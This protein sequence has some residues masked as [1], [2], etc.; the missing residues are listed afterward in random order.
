MQIRL[1]VLGPRESAPTSGASSAHAAAPA[2]DVLVSAP[3][4]TTLGSVAAALAGAVGARP[5]R[6]RRAPPPP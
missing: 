6:P 5:P 3:V 1:T 4:G 2:A